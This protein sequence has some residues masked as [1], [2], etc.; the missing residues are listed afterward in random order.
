MPDTSRRAVLTGAVAAVACPL[1]ASSSGHP[2]G[3]ALLACLTAAVEAIRQHY[4]REGNARLLQGAVAAL[5]PVLERRAEVAISKFVVGDAIQAIALLYEADEEDWTY[6]Y[7]REWARHVGT[8]L[9]RAT[10]MKKPAEAG[11]RSPFCRST[12]TRSTA[13][14]SRRLTVQ[15]SA[16]SC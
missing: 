6:K 3:E 15:G 16:A 5:A 8:R 10:G 14:A 1:P 2:S 11:R 9:K 13:F 7:M 4:D 12:Q